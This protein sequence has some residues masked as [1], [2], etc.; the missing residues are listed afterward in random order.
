M[1][2]RRLFILCAMLICVALV[3][4]GKSKAGSE[5]VTE[6]SETETETKTETE[7]EAEYESESESQEKAHRIKASVMVKYSKEEIILYSN[8]TCFFNLDVSVRDGEF[9]SQNTYGEFHI[10]EGESITLNLEDLAP[11]FFS[12]EAIIEDA[13]SE[14]P[15]V[16]EDSPLAAE[17]YKEIDCGLLVKFS[18]KEII[19]Y[20][21]TTC[22]FDL[23]LYTEDD[24][25]KSRNAYTK[26]SISKGET[27][28]LNLQDLAPG[29]FSENTIITSYAPLSTR[30]YIKK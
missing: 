2:K 28:T 5:S 6:V 4:C 8:T 9:L 1:K 15:Y 7:I 16:Y 26:L 18:S 22:F 30:E 20:S 21:D 14:T 11:G 17:N 19:V 25:F 24:N 10:L 23:Y 27:I 13:S 3:G 29:F 12:E